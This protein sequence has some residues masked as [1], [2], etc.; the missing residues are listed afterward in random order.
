MELVSPP[1]GAWGCW[2][3]PIGAGVGEGETEVATSAAGAV[4]GRVLSC[5]IVAGWELVG[6]GALPVVVDGAK[7]VARLLNGSYFSAPPAHKSNTH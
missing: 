2:T 6:G 7:V 1:T 4:D 5:S 3:L